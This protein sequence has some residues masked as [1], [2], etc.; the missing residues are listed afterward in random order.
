LDIFAWVGV[1]PPGRPCLGRLDSLPKRFKKTPDSG[2]VPAPAIEAAHIVP[3]PIGPI[4]ISG[5]HDER[6]PPP[7]QMAAW[8]ILI[9][10]APK[11]IRKDRIDRDPVDQGLGPQKASNPEFI[12][13]G[14]HADENMG[15]SVGRK[16]AISTARQDP[17][18]RMAHC[19]TAH[20]PGSCL[21]QFLRAQRLLAGLIMLY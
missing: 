12:P 17:S 8:P 20:N 21:V 13:L 19:F 15:F 5:F 16:A 4:F 9:A 1:S 18:V 7:D 6:D 10:Q 11:V 2:P 3:L 14:A